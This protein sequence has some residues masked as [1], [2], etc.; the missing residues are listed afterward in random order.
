LRQ[1]HAAPTHEYRATRLSASATAS[2]SAWHSVGSIFFCRS[3]L[4]DVL[5]V[6]LYQGT[7]TTSTQIYDCNDAGVVKSHHT[8]AVMV[9]TWQLVRKV[10]NPAV[11]ATKK[12]SL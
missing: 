11:I 9:I 5:L 3:S 6:A 1:E 2:L 4:E 8:L 10:R 12:Y 7:V